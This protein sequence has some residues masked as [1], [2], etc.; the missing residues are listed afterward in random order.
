MAYATVQYNKT[1]ITHTQ[2][3]STEN[4]GSKLL[5][6][7]STELCHKNSISGSQNGPLKNDNYI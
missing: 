5:K 1:W 2:T 4:L 6:S 3:Q 7:I